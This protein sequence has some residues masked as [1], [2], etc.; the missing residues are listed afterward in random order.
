MDSYSSIDQPEG[1]IGSPLFNEES[2]VSGHLYSDLGENDEISDTLFGSNK[3]FNNEDEDFSVVAYFPGGAQYEK[4][5]ATDSDAS[6]R[7]VDD[8]FSKR[9][10]RKKFKKENVENFEEFA[11]SESET[12]VEDGCLKDEENVQFDTRKK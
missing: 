1:G 9:I 3:D 4:D 2:L 6:D 5:E 8:Y 7:S 10:S 11:P 12:N